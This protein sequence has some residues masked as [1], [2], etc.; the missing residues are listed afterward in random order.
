[1]R[2]QDIKSIKIVFFGT[3]EFAVP[4]LKALIRAQYEVA[5][6]ITQ[7]DKPVGRKQVLSPPPIK[8]VAKKLGLKIFQPQSLKNETLENLLKIK[9][10]KLKI[11]FGVVAAYGKIIPKRYLDVPKYGFTNIH[12]SLLPKYRGPS[13]V[14]TAIM[15]GEKETGITIMKMDEQ[16]DHGPILA[17]REFSIFNFQFSNSKDLEKKLAELGAKLLIETLPKY[18]SGQIKPESQDHGQATFT[19]LLTR[20]D[21]LIDWNKTAEEIYNQIRALNPEPGTWT[22]WKNKV[23]NILSCDINPDGT[24]CDVVPSGTVVKINS[25]IAVQ[26]KKCYLI[27]K[28]IQLESGKEMDAKSFLNGHPDFLSSRLE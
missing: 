19:K 15:N 1:M 3:S 7:P 2:N 12:P 20:E 9:N 14:Q 27:L 5:A 8:T 22:I 23:L 4:T 26:T 10:S 6:I 24:T 16:I 21:G 13:P 25:R 28:Q 11:D 18:I 17:K